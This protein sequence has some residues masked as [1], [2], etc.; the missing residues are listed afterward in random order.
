M[1]PL[2]YLL[3]PSLYR[4]PVSGKCSA[5]SKRK[6]NG[7]PSAPAS[8]LLVEEFTHPTRM[9]VY[10]IRRVHHEAIH[11]TPEF[12]A[13]PAAVLLYFLGR[14]EAGPRLATTSARRCCGPEVLRAKGRVRVVRRDDGHA[15]ELS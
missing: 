9:V 12:A 15:Y 13:R 7:R 11:D 4:L 2:K 6:L 3:T 5:L 14:Y 8:A 1:P 10:E